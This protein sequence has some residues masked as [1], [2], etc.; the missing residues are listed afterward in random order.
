MVSVAPEEVTVTLPVVTL[1]RKI[2]P[3]AGAVASTLN[4]TLPELAVE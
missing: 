1:P 4:A 2:F 3:A